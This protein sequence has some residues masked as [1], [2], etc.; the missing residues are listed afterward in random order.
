MSHCAPAGHA[1]AS[2]APAS[3]APASDVVPTGTRHLDIAL[4]GSP[5]AGKTSVFNRLTG[6][7]AR[8]G[9]YPGVTVTRTVGTARTAGGDVVTIEDLPG[10]YSLTPVSPDEQV[11][12]DVVTGRAPGTRAPDAFLVV[13]DATTLRRSLPLVAQTMALG[14]PVAV[15]LTMLDEMAA[16][17]GR[18]DVGGLAA[19]LGVPVVPVQGHRG[20]G[21]GAVR[22]LLDDPATWPQ[23]PV[24]PPEDDDEAAAWAA[25]VLAAASWS[26][27]RRHAPSATV[28][29]VLLHP[30]WGVLVFAAVV[31]TIFQVIFT[32]AA[33]LQGAVEAAFGWLGDRVAAAVSPPL[34]ADF[35]GTAVIGG[36]GAVLVFLPQ[37]ALLFLVLS[38][39]ETVGYMSR[40]AFLM[41]RVM[42]VSGLDGRSFV[43]MLS[44]FACAVPGIMATRTIP[45]SRDRLATILA[46]PLMT[47]SARLP[48]YVVLIGLLVDPSTRW[49]PVSAQGLTLFLLYLLG[50][51]AS[52]VAAGVLKATALRSDG[53]PFYMEM[54][55]YRLPTARTVALTMWESVRGF[56]RKAG[57]VI[58]TAS[59]ILWALMSFPAQDTSGMDPVAA[60]AYVLEHSYAATVGKAI[61]P[62][63]A[64]LGFDWRV[65]VG[66]VG[67]LAAREVFV[68]TMGQ[69]VAADPG[70]PADALA[71]LVHDD[72]PR[73]GEPV[74]DAPTVVALLIWFVFALQCMST[75]AVMRRE[76]GSWRWP[77]VA[78]GYLFALGWTLALAGRWITIAVTG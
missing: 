47:C 62:V 28:D 19:A 76:T 74:F 41:D 14:R 59:V 27:P 50:G 13:L 72:G 22:Q 7:R 16:R 3:D 56:L 30:V 20:R 42:A 57:T 38:L 43:A 69:V 15:V 8:T 11:V 68:S 45:S 36:V 25:S 40:A 78:F 73:A 17:G 63:F 12:V 71:S 70:D 31:F 5:N 24:L 48:V 53:L 2:D 4:V 55:P 52:M 51:L 37:I 67:S 34:L 39:L 1:P 23:P 10:T 60:D 49:G 66:L 46:L 64:P 29:R 54:P 65:D 58:L 6:L 33:P 26:A 32:V 44:G 21:T 61:E 75:L 77:A 35:L 18:L 9:N